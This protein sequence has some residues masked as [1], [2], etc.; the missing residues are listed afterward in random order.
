MANNIMHTR[1]MIG[2]L[3]LG[4]TQVEVTFDNRDYEVCAGE[5][6]VVVWNGYHNLVE[7][8]TTACDSATLVVLS[9]YENA[10]Y[11]LNLT[12]TVATGQRQYFKCDAHCVNGA[13]YSISCLADPV[14]SPFPPFPPPPSSPPSPPS[15]PSSP[16]SDSGGISGGVIAAIVVSA[17]VAALVILYL[18]LA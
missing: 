14:V 17:S 1:E 2:F 15:P 3:L 10:G 7:T 5:D 4:L 11:E 9:G 6:Y 13:K 16:T 8:A 18:V 12:S